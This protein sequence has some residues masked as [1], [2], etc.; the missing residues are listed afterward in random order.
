MTVRV[1]GKKPYRAAVVHGGPGAIG[2]AA[3]LAK[4]LAEYCGVMEPL[5]SEYTV[6]RQIE[7]LKGQITSFNGGSP[8]VLI[9]H[10]WGAWLCAMTAAKYPELASK[11][12]LVDSG[13]LTEQHVPQIEMRRL[14]HFTDGEKKRYHTLLAELEQ[15]DS[16][17][18]DRLLEQLGALCGK[19]DTYRETALPGD[20]VTLDGEMYSR[21]FPEAA[22]IRK[23]G[24]L[25]R[26]FDRIQCPLCIIHGEHDTHPPDGVTGPL[27]DRRIGYRF[28]LLSKCGHTPWREEYARA[29]FFK[30]LKREI[31]AGHN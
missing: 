16:A 15:K 31:P 13:P 30:I 17:A 20:A 18:K 4:G 21:V 12:I 11:L 28:H 2:S 24:Q 26:L 27:S 5:Q 19:A 29:H 25:L 1:H 14:S 23:T 22:E 6:S 8:L 9:G 3:G 10:S 7:E